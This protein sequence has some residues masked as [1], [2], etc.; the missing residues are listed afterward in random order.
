MDRVSRASS[1]SGQLM[2]ATRTHDAGLDAKGSRIPSKVLIPGSSGIS[3]V[4]ATATAPAAARIRPNRPPRPRG[5][6]PVQE[7]PWLLCCLC[8]NRVYWMKRFGVLLVTMLLA[9]TVT[10]PAFA[11]SRCW[12]CSTPSAYPKRAW[13]APK[14]MVQ[15]GS[16]LGNA[17]EKVG[18]AFLATLAVF[19]GD[20]S[21]PTTNFLH[22]YSKRHKIHKPCG[23]KTPGRYSA[24]PAS[25]IAAA[26]V[27]F[28]SSPQGDHNG[29][30][31]DRRCNESGQWCAHLFRVP[32]HPI[33]GSTRQDKPEAQ[34]HMDRPYFDVYPSP[35]KAAILS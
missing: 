19:E 12:S 23:T 1:A 10:T 21:T 15:P 11:A 8:G 34:H 4:P 28:P 18:A 25:V 17:F 5:Q 9:L 30:S 24:I 32:D 35:L 20:R 14:R 16:D 6:G 7:K 27:G 33:R 13:S 29:V 31:N 26:I 3:G 22:H 2:M